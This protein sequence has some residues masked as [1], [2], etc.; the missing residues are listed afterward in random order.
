[1][2]GLFAERRGESQGGHPSAPSRRTAGET[3]RAVLYARTS[4]SRPM[5]LMFVSRLAVRSRSSWASM[6]TVMD[7]T[8]SATSAKRPRSTP[9]STIV[10]AGLDVSVL[11]F[12]GTETAPEPPARTTSGTTVP[13]CIPSILITAVLG[14]AISGHIPGKPSLVSLVPFIGGVHEYLS[15]AWRLVESWLRRCHAG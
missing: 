8:L 2:G 10:A 9:T 11:W 12:R 13:L 3:R 5:L 6:S 1:M 7:C 15:G 14:R 4:S